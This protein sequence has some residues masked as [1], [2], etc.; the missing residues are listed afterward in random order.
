MRYNHYIIGDLVQAP[1]LETIRL[2]P[3]YYSSGATFHLPETPSLRHFEINHNISLSDVVV[4]WDNLTY[5]EDCL[6]SPDDILTI[7]YAAR[8]LVT[9]RFH[10]VQKTS[11][12][13]LP[14]SA[15]HATHTSLKH[16]FISSRDN[17]H[18]FTF[19]NLFDFP[20]LESFIF[21]SNR[22]PYFPKAGLISLFAR[23]QSLVSL[24]IRVLAEDQDLID[25]LEKLPSITDLSIS[26]VTYNANPMT[27]K[28]LNHLAAELPVTKGILF[29]F[30]PCLE[31]LHFTGIRNFAWSSLL[32]I[33]EGPVQDVGIRHPYFDSPVDNTAPAGIK[34]KRRLRCTSLT[35]YSVPGDYIDRDVLLSLMRIREAG[36]NVEILSNQG[37]LIQLSLSYHGL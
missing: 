1:M 31:I 19:I 7:L 17:P 33:L 4:Q 29:G 36:V 10:N 26:S 24:D 14:E 28:F 11:N 12:E 15:A 8:R 25:L 23:S 2:F 27:D 5:F 35:I 20:S 18:L 34:R 21:D 30:L 3:E 37:D 13:E 32:G 6:N 22:S 16:L 9:G